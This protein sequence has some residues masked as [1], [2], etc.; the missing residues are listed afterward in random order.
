MDDR[1][2]HRPAG[3]RHPLA[4]ARYVELTTFRRNG[5]AVR[6]PVW[7]AAPEDDPA[8][9]VVITVDGTGKTRRLAHTARVELRPCTVRGVVA[10]D[11]PTVHGRATVVRDR[12]GVARVRRAVVAKYGF[13]ARFSDL[14]E[15]VTS[16]VGIHRAPRAGIV[17]EVDA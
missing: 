10:P 7:V 14:V 13:Q 8:R 5:A 15:A 12:E 3:A 1:A 16:R 17:V 2:A 11:A 9:L 4:D 6:T